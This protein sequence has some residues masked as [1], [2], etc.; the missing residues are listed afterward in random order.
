MR[1]ERERN[2]E[3]FQFLKWGQARL[4][5][6]RVHPPGTG[7]LH[8]INLEQLATVVTAGGFDDDWL[9]PD[10]LIGTDSHTPMI[11][12]LG[13]LGWGVGGLEAEGVMFGI[14]V[15]MRVPD[16]V[17]VRLTGCLPSGVLA[18]DL[19]LR[20]TRQ[21]RAYGLN[22]QFVEFFGS[23]IATLSA[24]DRAVVSNMAPEYG[25]QTA[26][27]PVDRRTLDYLRSTGRAEAAIERVEAYCRRNH[28]WF[29]PDAPLRFTEVI[30]IDLAS[31]AVSIA[32]PSR[33]HDLIA[34]G[35]ARAAF[36]AMVGK[37]TGGPMHGAVAIAAITSCTNTTDPRLLVA[38][39]IM[40]RKAGRLGLKP[41]K[42]VKTSLSPGSPAAARTLSRAGLLADLEAIG[43]GI[44]GYGCMT[45]IGNSG[46]L[47]AALDDAIT[48]D[49]AVPVAV[50]S[51]NRN[52][53]GRVHPRLKAAFL[54]SPPLV[55]A[56]AL[57]GDINRDIA[58]DPIGKDRAGRD[59]FLADLWPSGDQ[60][61][62]VL[63]EFHDVEDY[64]RAFASASANA[65]WDSIT[66]PE[67]EQFPWD[68]ESTYLRR[69]PFTLLSEGGRL[70][71][72]RAHPIMVLGDDVTTDQISPAG[73]ISPES[74]AGRYLIEAGQDPAD[75][76]V[77]ASRRG[78]FE[79]MVR[80]LFTNL[81]VINLLDETLPPGS[82]VDALTG[83]AMPLHRLARLYEDRGE[84]S[85]L[86]AGERYGQGSSRDWAAKGL[87]LL[88]VR[89]VLALSF[90]RIHR[91]NLIG[92][93]ILPLRLPSDVRPERLRL[94]RGDLMEI[95]AEPVDV[96][97]RAEV[98][99][100]VHYADGR[101][102]EITARV[103][104]ETELEVQLLRSGGIIPLILDREHAAPRPA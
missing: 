55:V 89:S 72:Y 50:I 39:G 12:A 81:S 28:L 14:P 69:P 48:R 56:F 53:A 99:V 58:T 77:Y 96:H 103:E 100:V 93:G 32:G 59:V 71:S 30:D 35:E 43:F 37:R 95:A 44:V 57:A 97:A 22:G 82:S 76:N 94:R 1:R 29:D 36:E 46:P 8:T 78:N 15:V 13:V 51:G 85:V 79:V 73:A 10:T 91:T 65:A 67:G 80:G 42:W 24:G 104:V 47:V 23:G 18:T 87:A 101:R 68:E 92:M 6:F 16:V 70:G 63:A 54:A 49:G 66:V 3:R 41:P 74:E 7:I 75:L 38:A 11:N 9:F 88:G 33:P 27:F 26:Y 90:E 62:A 60:I 4:R 5:N 20:V 19:A 45:C 21:L 86:I 98:P 52:F 64:R 61:D 84:S 34:P 102:T 17:G 83:E 2:R 31:V 25:A 40:A